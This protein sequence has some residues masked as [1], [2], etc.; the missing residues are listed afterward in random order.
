LD[1]TSREIQRPLWWFRSRR[2]QVRDVSTKKKGS[3]RKEGVWVGREGG[4]VGIQAGVAPLR[5]SLAMERR[6]C[7]AMP[8][9]SQH[10]QS[11][12]GRRLVR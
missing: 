7:H 6:G 11:A 8:F 10:P 4:G 3:S 12:N 5:G 9:F 1:G 2:K